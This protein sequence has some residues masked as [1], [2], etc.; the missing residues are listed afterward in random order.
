MANKRGAR[1][2]RGGS[3]I[4]TRAKGKTSNT[5]PTETTPSE[6]DSP[7][8]ET[9]PSE[10]H[11]SVST[12][13]AKVTSK[14]FVESVLTPYGITLIQTQQVLSFNDHFSFPRDVPRNTA[15]RLKYYKKKF[16]FSLFLTPSDETLETIRQEYEV[17]VNCRCPEA[18]FQDFALRDII[19]CRVPLQD[20]RT[21]DISI[22]PVRAL[23][24]M[25]ER[26][27]LQLLPRQDQSGKQYNWDINPDC[28]YYI[29]LSAFPAIQR[30][31]I[32]NR[33]PTVYDQ[34]FCSYFT[35][36]FKKD[37]QDL[38]T[39]NNQI[40]IASSL[41]LYNRW[42]LKR[43]AL[44]VSNKHGNWPTEDKDQLRHYCIT[45]AGADWKVWSLIPKTYENWSG[46]T[47]SA[48]TCG[49]C[50]VTDS[51]AL[52]FSILNDIHCWGLTVHAESC[53]ADV[54]ATFEG[55]PSDRITRGPDEIR[56]FLD[57]ARQKEKSGQGNAVQKTDDQ[58]KE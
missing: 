39:A 16:P 30:S 47:M 24:R 6:V 1:G 49:E 56:H 31:Q 23:Q 3:H 40:A 50:R 5:S 45:L 13:P 43:D 8:T 22:R 48:L 7:L 37:N 58:S 4:P 34:A 18:E 19:F 12:V 9:A 55:G 20:P 2:G 54:R 57:Q 33:L 27:R 26:K 35:I 15:E 25:A 28:A 21:A 52:L 11:T 17:M 36:E 29:S 44:K 51:L 53:V 14:D 42:C 46:C 10:A 38:C 41:S 32:R